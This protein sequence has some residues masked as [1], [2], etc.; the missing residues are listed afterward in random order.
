MAPLKRVPIK[1][2]IGS[3]FPILYAK[4]MGV[5]P[6]REH[7]VMF[8]NKTMTV[9]VCVGTSESDGAYTGLKTDLTNLRQ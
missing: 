7:Q 2:V 4:N 8:L 1:I 9:S 6:F 3:N 5:I